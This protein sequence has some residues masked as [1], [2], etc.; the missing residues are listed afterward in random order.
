LPQEYIYS[1]K[2]G[3]DGVQFGLKATNN[4]QDAGTYNSKGKVGNFWLVAQGPHTSPAA[5]LSATALLR[6]TVPLL[7]F[8]PA[9]Q[10]ARWRRAA[11]AGT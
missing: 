7:L 11:H 2:Y 9:C 5:L 8:M 6:R 1:F 10:D 4:N 3:E